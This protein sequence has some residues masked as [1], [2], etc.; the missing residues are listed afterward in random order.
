MHEKIEK[1]SHGLKITYWNVN[2][3]F[4]KSESY[5]KLMDPLFTDQINNYD[6]IGLSEIHCGEEDQLQIEGYIT[7][8]TIRPKHPKAR[9][10][11]GGIAIF[12]KEEVAKGIKRIKC[13]TGN[14]IWLQLNKTFFNLDKHIYLCMAYIS[15]DNSTYSR[16]DDEDSL[17]PLEKDIAKFQKDGNI[18]ILG[19][20]NA[21][22]G[23][24]S[25]HIRNDSDRYLPIN[26]LNIYNR[27][28]QLETRNNQDIQLN[29][30]G[31]SLIDL[32]ISSQIR[33]MNGRTLG[34]L[35]GRF[36][37]HK[38]NGSSTVDYCLTSEPLSQLIT[39][40]QVHNFIGDLSDH[41]RISCQISRIK[42]KTIRPQQL[43]L[44]P[45][46]NRLHW[47]EKTFM[48]ALAN[49]DTKKAIKQFL[50]EDIV[51]ID[52]ALTNFNKLIKLAASRLRPRKNN[53]KCNHHKN[54][55]NDSLK[56]LR[57]KLHLQGKLVEQQPY[58]KEFRSKYFSTLKQYRKK[59]KS[60]AKKFKETTLNKLDNLHEH[61]P[62]GYWKLIK[63][64]KES[65]NLNSKV[66][67]I[68]PNNWYNHFKCMNENIAPNETKHEQIQ[69][70]LIS[71]EKNPT[72]TPLD[73]LITEPEISSAIHTLKNNK[74]P[75][76]DQITNEMLKCGKNILCKPLH[77]LFNS[78]L[79]SGIYP[80]A[81]AKGYITPLHK[82]GNI[83]DPNNY[84][85]ITISSS[86]GKLFNTIMNTRLTSFL[87]D[88]NFLCEE[89]IGFRKKCRTADHMF[90]L[91]CI[92]DQYKKH[93]KELYICFV[94]FSKAFDRV[95]HEGLFYKLI[96]AGISTKFYNILKDM[97]SKILLHVKINNNLSPV[98]HSLMGVRQG[99]NL[100]PTLFNIFIND[101]PTILDNCDP[102]FYKDLQIKCLMYADDLVILSETPTGIQKAINHLSN[103]CKT[104]K[105]EINTAK[106]KILCCNPLSSTQKTIKYDNHIIEYVPQYTYLGITFCSNGKFNTAIEELHKKGLKVF[107]KLIKML[108]PLP[109]IKTSLHLFDHL[110]K[111]ILLY[112]CEIWGPTNFKLPKSQ[113]EDPTCNYN[114]WK[115]VQYKFPIEHKF[116][117]NSD[118]A[119]EKLHLKFCRDILGVNSKTTNAGV[120]GELGRF[121]L[122][123]DIIKQ[124][125]SY[126][127]HLKSNTQ[128]TILR[129]VF[130][131]FN[132]EAQNNRATNISN[133]SQNIENICRTN[134]D[135]PHNEYTPKT[136]KKT[137]QTR[138][139]LLWKDLV[140]TQ[141]SRTGKG[142]NKLRTYNK[143]KQWH[144]LETY[145]QLQ[146]IKENQKAIARFR[147]SAHK[148]K[149][150]TDRYNS[151]NKYIPPEKRICTNCEL[152]ITED[153]IHFLMN[154]PNYTSMRKSL[155]NIAQELCEHFK[156]LTTE[157][158]FIW[159][160]SNENEKLIHALGL[161]L[162]N[163]F[164]KRQ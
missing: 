57:S 91:K 16:K 86:V 135:D 68:S 72:F 162:R 7:E 125:Q 113:T 96:S 17:S 75:G 156:E 128:N 95:W 81:W 104:W 77:K 11:S 8:K 98:F 61:N 78:V 46:P 50:C 144:G 148:L 37:C 9:K 25:D 43:H 15:P 145:L 13:S 129:K 161:Y 85:G 99:D 41:S 112:G 88:N 34:D 82:K 97:Y 58:N 122:Y 83:R 35:S 146:S 79:S 110:I 80:A 55:H 24:K 87:D 22:T 66:S 47:D 70:N 74:S 21:R 52:S 67:P 118:N 141:E 71:L 53:N 160:M 60:E 26:N 33:I 163:A 107:F 130:D 108:K 150:E 28:E 69:N 4:R 151:S 93:K 64:M 154:C 54:W 149:I 65:E 121:P 105:L 94:D 20:L 164:A 139:K 32:C 137:L 136:L 39:Y 36:T 153:E 124:C 127:D 12:M 18:M 90:I 73:Q 45:M 27:D 131:L 3:L 159:I 51:D 157:N 23:N 111:P 103:Y 100:S 119:Y 19:D 132:N 102:T 140:S 14:Y 143:F 44:T 48:E 63:S 120:Y 42:Y 76:L 123:I 158:K 2:G 152:S 6:I 109:T 31:Q 59:C 5:C 116:I 147:L 40:F 84:R 138:Y 62:Q 106:T 1:V 56:V 49:N 114:Y 115:N 30:R 126:L 38:H 92:I 101:I 29:P 134:S 155:F 117:N 10:H 133:F 142:N 89:Q